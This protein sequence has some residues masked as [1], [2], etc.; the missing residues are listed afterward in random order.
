MA[1]RNF[2]EKAEWWNNVFRYFPPLSAAFRHFPPFRLFQDPANNQENVEH[3]H[4]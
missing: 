2:L 3:I 1:F 4:Q